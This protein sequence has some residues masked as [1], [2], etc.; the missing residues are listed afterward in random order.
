MKKYKNIIVEAG[1][2]KQ[3]NMK[4]EKASRRK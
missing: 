2:R 4:F 1:L 3:E